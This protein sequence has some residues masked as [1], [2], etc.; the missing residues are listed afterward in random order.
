M[1]MSKI[2]ISVDED[3][4]VDLFRET[5]KRLN[6]MGLEVSDALSLTLEVDG[7]L[8]N[9]E[10]RG[11]DTTFSEV[12]NE[13]K[14]NVGTGNPVELATEAAREDEDEGNSKSAHN[15]GTKNSK[16]PD[17]DEIE[18]V[19]SSTEFVTKER[20]TRDSG[21]NPYLPVLEVLFSSRHPLRSDQ[22]FE[23]TEGRGEGNLKRMWKNH[24]VDRQENDDDTQHWH[25]YTLA[26]RGKEIV[27]EIRKEWSRSGQLEDNM[28]AIM[29]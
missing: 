25:K 21:D 18:E 8:D 20:I 24:L 17:K 16:R 13:N 22:I 11:T 4:G 6:K 15:N 29:G 7:D 12:Q 9:F 19:L 28:S 10:S 3:D 27:L 26:P 1:E 14:K 2:T 23:L 5:Q